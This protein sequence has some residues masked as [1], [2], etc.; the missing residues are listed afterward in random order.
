MGEK[1]LLSVDHRQ[2]GEITSSDF[3]ETGKTGQSSEGENLC[4]FC[5]TIVPSENPFCINCGKNI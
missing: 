4:P 5:N 1:E 2:I 3:K